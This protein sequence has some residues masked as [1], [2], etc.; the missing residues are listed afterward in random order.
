MDVL[1]KKFSNKLVNLLKSN[2]I[3]KT[4]FSKKLNISRTSLDNW[5]NGSVLPSVYK[6]V[7]IAQYFNVSTDYLLGDYEQQKSYTQL[8][9]EAGATY[10]T[11][12][13]ELKQRL[14][15]C[16]RELIMQRELSDQKDKMITL[17]EKQQGN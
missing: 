17:L 12:I 1:R 7:E 2:N 14:D 16:K 4:E 3:G 15:S 8:V 6:L 5:L 11:T 9:E 10:N 13:D